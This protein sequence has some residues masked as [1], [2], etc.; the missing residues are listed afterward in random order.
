MQ[1]RIILIKPSIYGITTW[2]IIIFCYLLAVKCLNASCYRNRAFGNLT[3]VTSGYFIPGYY[4]DFHGPN[5]DFSRLPFWASFYFFSSVLSI[6]IACF[7]VPFQSCKV[8]LLRLCLLML[9]EKSFKRLYQLLHQLENLI[10]FRRF[11]QGVHPLFAM[12]RGIFLSIEMENCLR[13]G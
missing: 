9:A 6:R 3:K 5:T 7:V 1:V 2:S 10:S 11:S 4:Q 8:P 13:F 12:P